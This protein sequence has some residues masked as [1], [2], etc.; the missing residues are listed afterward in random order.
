MAASV[1]EGIPAHLAE[2]ARDTL[3]GAVAAAR[4]L[5]ELGTV[6]LA[7]ARAAFTSGLR[8][9][10]T[11]SALIVCGMAVLVV[12]SLRHARSHAEPEGGAASA[13]PC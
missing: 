9:T 10:A 4:Q 12:T 8:V 3:G 7:T 1:P 2:G 11:V 13:S 6:L 5:P